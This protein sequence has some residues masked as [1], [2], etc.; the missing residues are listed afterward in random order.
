MSNKVRNVISLSIVCVIQL[1]IL[2]AYS[3]MLPEKDEPKSENV[4]SVFPNPMCGPN[5]L[6][7]VARLFGKD[8]SLLRITQLCG[9]YDKQQASLKDMVIAANKIGLEAIAV[10]LNYKTLCKETKNVYNLS[11]IVQIQKFANKRPSYRNIS[12]ASWISMKTL[13]NSNYWSFTPQRVKDN[14]WSGTPEKTIEFM[15]KVNKP[16]IAY[17]VMAAGAIHPRDGFK[18]AFEN[19]A[20]FICAG[21]F[22]FQVREDVIIAKDILS[23]KLNRQRRWKA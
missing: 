13:H 21:M 9:I 5:C 16:W 1:L 11:L 3:K 23:G 12:R 14:V 19:G 17:K 18:Y 10:K 15:R 7:M 20:D 6:W 2:P 22:D 8:I 4:S